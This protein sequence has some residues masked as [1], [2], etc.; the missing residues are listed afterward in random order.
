MGQRSKQLV[1]PM[2]KRLVFLS[3]VQRAIVR[4][5]GSRDCLPWILKAADRIPDEM[6]AEQACTKVLR[7]LYGGPVRGADR[8]GR[9]T[10]RRLVEA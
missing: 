10:G 6:S 1:T 8:E 3:L 5:G 7:S 2:S 9:E 4:R